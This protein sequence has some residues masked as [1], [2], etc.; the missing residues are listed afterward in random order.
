MYQEY[1]LLYVGVYSFILIDYQ[2]F[3]ASLLAP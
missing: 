1:T 3:S 2:C